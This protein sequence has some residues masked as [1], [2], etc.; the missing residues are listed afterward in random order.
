MNK[1]LLCNSK[2]QDESKFCK[3]CACTIMEVATNILAEDDFELAYDIYLSEVEEE[4]EKSEFELKVGEVASWFDK[5]KLG[6][7]P[8][9]KYIA[10]ID[11]AIDSNGVAEYNVVLRGQGVKMGHH[12][13]SL[14]VGD[15]FA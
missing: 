7:D 2:A 3:K 15:C 10:S 4:K 5:I 13:P 1:C 6:Q 12:P 8:G 9:D 11:T 14:F